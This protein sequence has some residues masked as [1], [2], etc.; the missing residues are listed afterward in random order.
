MHIAPF[1]FEL[2]KK[3]GMLETDGVT[4]T[5]EYASIKA[6]SEDRR[7]K[8]V[9]GF[10]FD[11][12]V[13]IS[14]KRTGDILEITAERDGLKEIIL[15]NYGADKV[16]MFNSPHFEYGDVKT[17]AFITYIKEEEESTDIAVVNG[18]YMWYKGELVFTDDYNKEVYISL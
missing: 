3:Q 12:S 17:N 10:V 4:H 11:D 15:L 16:D 6:K 7:Q 5:C 9:R 18:F 13:K 14:K 1:D 2:V 8:F